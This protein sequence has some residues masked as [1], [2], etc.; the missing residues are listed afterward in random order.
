MNTNWTIQIGR[1]LYGFS[2][3]FLGTTLLFTEEIFLI[4]RLNTFVFLNN[5]VESRNI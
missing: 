2:T 1:F 3:L 5:A 4:Y